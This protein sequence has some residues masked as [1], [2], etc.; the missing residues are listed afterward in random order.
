MPTTV[1][2]VNAVTGTLTVA[3]L[4]LNNLP[5]VLVALPLTTPCPT[6]VT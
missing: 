3:L 5:L 1:D 6:L 2:T 4:P